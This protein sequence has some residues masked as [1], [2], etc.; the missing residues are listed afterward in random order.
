MSITSTTARA[1]RET[2][3][4]HSGKRARKNKMIWAAQVLLAAVFAFAATPKLAGAHSA[5]AMF[6]Q[7][8]AGQWLRYLAGTAE[9]AGAIG[10]LIPRLAGLAAAGLAADMAGAT[11]INIAVH[12]PAAAMTI[13][14]CAALTVIAR[15]RW[16]HTTKL[17]AA[18]TGR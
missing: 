11:I 8:G 18:R 5:V 14:L 10:L 12:S 2:G 13:P 9:L 16:E 4:T 7:I 17:L 3:Q 6:G 1:D 15:A